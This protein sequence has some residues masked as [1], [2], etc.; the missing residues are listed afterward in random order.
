[1]I[2]EETTLVE[3]KCDACSS[4]LSVEDHGM[5]YANYGVLESQFGWLSR[6]DTIPF[7]RDRIE[8]CENCWEK[9]LK[10]IGLTPERFIK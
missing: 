9:A 1:M 6:F 2:K 5:K 8:I 3:A 7:H 10:A 4:D